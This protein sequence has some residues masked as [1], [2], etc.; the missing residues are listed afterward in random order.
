MLLTTV[1]AQGAEETHELPAEP[2][3]FG[4]IAFAILAALVVGVLMFGKG[5]PHA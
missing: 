2:M 3:V 1:F 4:L 5:R